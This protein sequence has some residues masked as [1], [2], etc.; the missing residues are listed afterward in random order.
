MG[1][2]TQD[3]TGLHSRHMAAVWIGVGRCWEAMSQLGGIQG[4]ASGQGSPTPDRETLAQL[5]S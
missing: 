3:T 2:V 5:F 1:M 4:R